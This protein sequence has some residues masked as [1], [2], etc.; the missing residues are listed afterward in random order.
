MVDLSYIPRMFPLRPTQVAFAAL[1]IALLLSSAQAEDF[2]TAKIEPLLKERCYEC[3]SHKGKM[4]GGLTLDS[5]SG[6]EQGGDDGPAVMA[7]KPDES[8]LIKMVRWADDDHRMPPKKKL[9]ESEIA[10]L[11]EWVKIGAPDPRMA[12]AARPN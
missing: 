10:L 4:K 9:A 6:W 3:H 1:A 12:P 7:G 5:R 8:L 2:F 11:E